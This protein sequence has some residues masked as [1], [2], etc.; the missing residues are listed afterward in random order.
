MSRVSQNKLKILNWTSIME[1]LFFIWFLES[2]FNEILMR[3]MIAHIF[4]KNLQSNVIKCSS[5]C[6]EFDSI[7]ISENL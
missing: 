2:Y 7:S 5:C 6:K 1:I 4:N 3:F